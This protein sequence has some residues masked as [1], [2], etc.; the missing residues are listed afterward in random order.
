MKRDRTRRGRGDGSIHQRKDG[1]WTAILDIGADDHGKRQRQQLYARTRT[2][3]QQKLRDLQ[4][5]V[6]AGKSTK[7]SKLTL[8]KFLDDWLNDVV[9]SRTRA[10]TFAS[11]ES[12]IRLH[13]KPRIGGVKLEELKPERVQRL[14]ATLALD[15]V[16]SRTQRKAHAV[17]HKALA[18]AVRTDLLGRNPTDFV[19]APHYQASEMRPLSREQIERFLIAAK[20]DRLEALYVLAVFSGIREGEL[21]ALH[22]E[23]VNFKERSLLVH[24]SLQDLNGKLRIGET[25]TKGSKRSVMLSKLVIDALKRHQKAQRAEG[26]VD[27]RLV[28]IDNDGGPLRRQNVARR[29]FYPLLK[30]ARLP[31]IRFHDLRHTAATTLGNLGV[32][33]K[34]VSEQ[35]GHSR[36]STTLDIYS[37]SFPSMQHEAIAKLNTAFSKKRRG[38]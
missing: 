5:D 11:Y 10:S 35:L 12:T 17:L 21:F 13:I 37:H 24:R 31:Q 16:G 8:G 23:D 28:F 3:V 22:W 26:F 33:L 15:K 27:S 38:G 34:V 20:E 19:E 7:R 32:P 29:S 2:E 1:L 6:A 36:P 4:L 9:K 30:R 25:K 14:Y 18:H